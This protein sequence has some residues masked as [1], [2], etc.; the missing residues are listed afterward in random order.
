MI[1]EPEESAESYEASEA[2]M[3]ARLLVPFIAPLETFR[4]IDWSQVNRP[5]L[6][7]I[8]NSP[9]IKPIRDR[10]PYILRPASEW[11]DD[12]GCVIWWH[13]PVCEPPE[14]GFGP[15]SGEL[16]SDGT[17]T[18]CAKGIESGWLTH[19]SYIPDPRFTDGYFA[20]ARRVRG[21]I[22]AEYFKQHADLKK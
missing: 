5:P 1:E 14:I 6:A 10:N 18:A 22:W 9:A 21:L 19:W 20:D 12:C 7:F 13:L 2:I 8:E 3:N 15:G 16:N 4:D 17:P 11:S